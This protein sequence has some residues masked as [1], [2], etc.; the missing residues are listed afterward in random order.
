MLDLVASITKVADCLQRNIPLLTLSSSHAG[1]PT[2]VVKLA[3]KVKVF[4]GAGVFSLHS[5]P[6]VVEYGKLCGVHS[7]S[8]TACK[9]ARQK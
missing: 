4:S 1:E 9:Q 5:G 2:V 7:Y 8:G 3:K 6:H